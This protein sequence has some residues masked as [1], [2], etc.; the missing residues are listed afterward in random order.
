MADVLTW[1]AM[2]GLLGA[3]IYAST[4]LTTCAFADEGHQH[5]IRCFAEAFTSLCIGTI[6]AAAFAPWLCA[7]MH[8]NAPQD[9]RALSAVIGMLANSTA[10][11][12]INFLSETVLTR[13]KGGH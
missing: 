4:K 11:G 9:I 7:Y 2:W 1:P 3:M 6:S 8:A 10:P 12:I 5:L 13:I